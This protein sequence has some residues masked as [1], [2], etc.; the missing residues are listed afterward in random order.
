MKPA[1]F[2]HLHVHTEYSLLDGASRI[3]ALLERGARLKMPAMAITDHGTMSGVVKFYKA[4]FEAGVRPIIG[5][6]LYV[7]PG[8][9]FDKTGGTKSTPSHLTLLARDEIGYHNL[10]V[11]CS[12][13]YQEGFY[14]RPRI[15]HKLF[16]SHYQ[17]LIALSGCLK[18]EI[19]R[20][21]LENNREK[22][23]ACL[24]FYSEL[25][26]KEN[27]YL[28]I[29]DHGIP[30][31]KQANKLL[32]ELS[33]RTG[34]PLV[35]SNDCHYVLKEDAYS[36]EVLLC[37]QTARQLEDSNRMKLSS[38]EFYLKSVAEMET[39]FGEVPEAIM[40]T[41]AI[42]DRCHHEMVFGIDLL[43]DFIPP[44]GKR[45]DQYLRELCE[46]AIERRYGKNSD[47]IQSRLNHELEVIEGKK[48]VSYFLIVWDLIRYAKE[49]HIPIGP[50]RGSAAGSIV[51]YLLGITDI[52]PFRHDLLFERFL[53]PNR[54]TMPD[55]DIDISDLGRAELIHY[56]TDKYGSDHVAQ[57]ITFGS[58]KARAV[59]RDVGR[60]MGI[61]YGDVDKIAKLVPPGPKVTLQKALHVEKQLQ[62]LYDQDPQLKILFDICFKLEGISR[63]SG[64]HA[65]GVLISRNPLIENVPLCRGKDD[66]VITQFDM[67]DSEEIGLLK[68]D[69]L[70][71]R[72]LSVIQGAIDLVEKTQGEV[73]ELEAIPLDDPDTF[74]LLSKANTLGVFQLEGSGMRDL[75]TR[76]GLKTFDDILALV[77][78]FRPGPMHMLEDYISRKHGK[79]KIKYDHPLLEPILKDTYGVMLYQEQVMLIANKLA[80]F[81]MA[82]ADTLRQAMAK[83]KA[84]KMAQ[85][86]EAF[87][88]GA[89]EKGVK[90]TVAEKIFQD[91][92]RFAEYGFNK[93]HSAAYAMIAYRTAYLKT[94]FPRE[95]MASLLT[96]EINNMDKMMLYVAECREMGIEVLPPDIN[97]SYAMFTVV[98]DNIRFGMNA[99]K[100]VGKGAVESILESRRNGGPFTTWFN[101]LERIDLSAVNKRVL[102]SLIK[103]GAV[104]CLP[105]HRSQKM[106]CL[107]DAL[108]RAHRTRAD[109]VAGQAT[110]FD[111]F[112]REDEKNGITGFADIE[113]WH[114]NECL[115]MEKELMGMYISGHPLMAYEKNLRAFSSHSISQLSGLKDQSKV[116]IGGIIEQI[117]ERTSK[118]TGKKFAFCQLE[119]LTGVV[120]ITAW[121]KEFQEFESLIQ[122]GN[123]VFVEGRVTTRDR[124][125]N[126]QIQ[127]VYP[128]DKA[129]E[130][131][132]QALHINLHLATVD[133]ES[134]LQLSRVLK[135]TRGR[136]PVYLDFDYATGEKVLMKSGSQFRVKCT[137]GLI[138]EI[139]E[140]LGE[141]TAYIK[142]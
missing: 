70:G 132:S 71:L 118:K 57:I 16:S 6:E 10:L 128:L 56:T 43:P 25:M 88:A 82:K 123:I 9:R 101:L 32:I 19:P 141:N 14:Y 17:G 94:H 124:G 122:P 138:N 99:I 8:S 68:M 45:P 4:A 36:Q 131:F 51:A 1:D 38:E 52:D 54:T 116:R 96:S 27:F 33:R 3:P 108:Q 49:N 135:N 105:G 31:Q 112:D 98:G 115:S 21:L 67:Y 120:E 100:N 30:E 129:Q 97:E 107:N 77:A 42:A 12:K 41:R 86:G 87:V 50:G 34:V 75:S 133:R 84:D 60:V 90:K 73:I 109:R 65:A 106:D 29:M 69:F 23:E 127:Q 78:L 92:S 5:A 114:Q 117:D 48:F 111:Q 83:K 81:T 64:T 28:E 140:I 61:P 119:D 139:E 55:I 53:N 80:G 35:A 142:T 62:K 134:L 110:L 66:E 113:E 2:V 7:A 91:M 79:V 11:L 22:A 46:Q 93:S 76:I 103:C 58:M 37:I 44:P 89:Q 136:C 74:K 13:A 15:D 72:T 95:F 137:P 18:G 130:I 47:R 39:L 104:D 26:G 24:S 63:H 20:A 102:E 125:S 59:I 85:L 126:V 121:N 40:N